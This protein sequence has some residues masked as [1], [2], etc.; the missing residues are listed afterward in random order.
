MKPCSNCPF[1]N[2]N[3]FG[4]N[5]CHAKDI[6]DSLMNDAPFHCHKTIDY[7]QEDKA[8]QVKNASL[9]Q[10]AALFL[11]NVR[12]D[13]CRANLSF[14]LGVR[15]DEISGPFGKNEIAYPTVEAFLKGVTSPPGTGSD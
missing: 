11:E 7:D 14:R 8:A 10:G 9:C 13:G 3:H 4:L 2:G 5:P 15:S 1:K 6:A 12:P